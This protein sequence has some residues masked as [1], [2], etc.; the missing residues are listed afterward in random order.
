M[1]DG[2][3][4]FD[5]PVIPDSRGRIHHF[6]R[7]S[8]PMFADFNVQEVYFSWIYSGAVKAW[9]KHKRMTLNYVVL[10]GNI[11]LVL[12]TDSGEVQEIYLGENCPYKMVRIPPGIWNGFM[13][14]D[15]SA[16]VA[17]ITDCVHDPE[18]IIREEPHRMVYD[19]DKSRK[20]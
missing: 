5:L 4:I 7:K 18:E 15:G 10:V 3:Q 2:V 8:N 9:H 1:I 19:W 16:L 17:N 13:A 6:M 14:L 20:G 12:M 11:K